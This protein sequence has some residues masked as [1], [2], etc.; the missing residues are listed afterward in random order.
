VRPVTEYSVFSNLKLGPVFP[1][2]NGTFTQRVSFITFKRNQKMCADLFRKLQ[3][4][5]L[6]TAE[7]WPPTAASRHRTGCG[8]EHWRS[9]RRGQAAERPWCRA[10]GQRVERRCECRTRAKRTMTF[11]SAAMRTA[12]ALLLVNATL[13]AAI[14]IGS[15]PP[16]GV[17]RNLRLRGGFPDAAGVAA[18]K[19]SAPCTLSPNPPPPDL[20]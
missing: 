13:G 7:R 17:H 16:R 18:G 2:G 8:L 12:A 11:A 6:R 4:V 15:V 9:S 19:C 14:G 20:F 10:L 3:C 5:Y 1:G